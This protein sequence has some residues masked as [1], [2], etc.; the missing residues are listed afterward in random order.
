MGKIATILFLFFCSSLAHAASD[1]GVISELFA[2]S[3]G[4]IAIK[5]KGGFPNSSDQCESF[6]GWAG[7]FDADPILKS[8]LLAAKATGDTV[9]LSIAG[10]EGDWIKVHAVYIK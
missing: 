5:L 7:N 6:N 2:S 8:A 10:C 1:D 3:N 9:T 4:A